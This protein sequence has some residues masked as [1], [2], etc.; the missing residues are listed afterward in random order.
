MKNSKIYFQW[1]TVVLRFQKYDLMNFLR[2]LKSYKMNT[3]FRFFYIIEFS[4]LGHISSYYEPH[5]MSNNFEKFQYFLIFHKYKSSYT[6]FKLFLEFIIS[7]NISK[8]L[9]LT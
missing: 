9:E 5:N 4:S 7:S 6:N 8:T 1:L 2:V 3:F